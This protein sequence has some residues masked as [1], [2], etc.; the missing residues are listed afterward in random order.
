VGSR[1]GMKLR[2]GTDIRQ[3]LASLVRSEKRGYA[4]DSDEE[5]PLAGYL[6]TMSVYGA[7][8][9]AIA[10]AT[11][12]TGCPVP[13]GLD[14]RQVTLSAAAI[15]KLSRLL[16][17]DPVTSPLRVP[18]TRYQGT[19]GPAELS[20]EVRGTGAQKAVGELISCPFCVSVWVAT[21]FAA[22][23]IYL[24]R[25]TRLAIGTL[26]ALAGADLLQYLHAWVQQQTT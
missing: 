9:A 15:H 14:P 4:G 23:L 25:T 16:A 2:S 18:F 6:G 24:P 1:V 21:G 10:G 5:R 7:V 17:K 12:A 19:A 3:K 11:R 22:G 20:E 13:D 26:A 8:V